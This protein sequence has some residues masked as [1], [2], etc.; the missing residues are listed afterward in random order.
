MGFPRQEYWSGVL[1]PSPRD[2]PTPGTELASPAFA[3]KFFTTKLPE[4]SYICL[5][6]DNFFFNVY[7]AYPC[8]SILFQ[9]VIMTQ[10]AFLFL[11]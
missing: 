6:S 8:F 10:A 1:F 7:A 9:E 2:L 3:G 5:N 11:K 4:K